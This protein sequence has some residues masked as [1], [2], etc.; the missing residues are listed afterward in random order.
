LS[1][2]DCTKISLRFA[3]FPRSAR[4]ANTASR[5]GLKGSDSFFG[6]QAR[7]RPASSAEY[8]LAEHF[9][10]TGGE[11]VGRVDNPDLLIDHVVAPGD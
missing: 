5:A 10:S 2:S 4:P 6:G 11:W 8:P 7:D 3:A 9:M 1:H